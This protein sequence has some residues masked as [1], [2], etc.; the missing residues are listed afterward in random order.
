MTHKEHLYVRGIIPKGGIAIVGSRTPPAEAAEFA[1]QLAF[2][3]KKPVVAGLAPGIDV[4]AHR[5][6]LAAGVPTVAFVGYGFGRTDP[7]E[8]EELERAIVA[9]GGAVATLLPLGTPATPE[10]RIERDRLQAEHAAAVVL[11]CSNRN[12]GA[13][14]T[15]RFAR[16]LGVAQFAVT[17][18]DDSLG[19]EDWA[20]NLKAIEDGAT[21]LPFDVDGACELLDR[22]D[23]FAGNGGDVVA[24]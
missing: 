17:P 24:P 3:I 9:A 7:P 5:G 20:G 16:E 23:L 10:S 19:S 15:L 13:M 8:H 2:R 18:P 14:H 22:E 12:G 1:Y 11:V 21:P 4:A 6:A